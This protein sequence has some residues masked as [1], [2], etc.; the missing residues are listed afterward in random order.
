MYPATFLF[1]WQQEVQYLSSRNFQALIEFIPQISGLES[2]KKIVPH[3]TLLNGFRASKRGWEIAVGPSFRLV[4]KAKGFYYE[5]TWY[6]ED[7]REAITSFDP[8]VANQN[9]YPTVSRLDSRGDL[10]L[11]TS[12]VIGVGKT[13]KSGYLNIP[14]NVYF[15]PRKEGSVY[16][17]SFG[18]NIY[19][20][21]NR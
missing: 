10:K 21:I 17:L 6:L 1:G 19:G 3:I 12:L 4:N 7:Q 11:S 15:S 5:N 18:F 2:G 8:E 16:G 20:K 13:I 14:V 9:S